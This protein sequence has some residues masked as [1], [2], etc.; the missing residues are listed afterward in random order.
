M[1]IAKVLGT[2]TMNSQHPTMQGARL[3]L[4]VPLSLAE[5]RDGVAPQADEIVAWDDLGA[6]IGDL[7][8]ISEGAEAAQPFRPNY[9]PIDVYISAILDQLDLDQNL[10]R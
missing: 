4:I 7:V 2:V 1:R 3:R 5:L 6:G 9:K 10:L 8:A